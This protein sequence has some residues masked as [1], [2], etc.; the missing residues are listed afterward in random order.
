M[1]RAL[2]GLGREDEAIRLLEAGLAHLERR[3]KLQG[4]GF[5]LGIDDVQYLIVLGR[6]DE[7]LSRLTRAANSS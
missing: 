1:A 7:A 3:R 5:A 6:H 2:K 4:T